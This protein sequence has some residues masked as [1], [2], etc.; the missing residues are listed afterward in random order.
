MKNA[1]KGWSPRSSREVAINAQPREK[2]KKKERMSIK[3]EERSDFRFGGW[4]FKLL[5]LTCPEFP[6]IWADERMFKAFRL[7][8]PIG[9]TPVVNSKPASVSEMLRAPVACRCDSLF[10]TP[11]APVRQASRQC[12]DER[13]LEGP[14][15]F[16]T[17]KIPARLIYLQSFF[18]SGCQ[19]PSTMCFW[20]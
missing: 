5:G 6:P 4:S 8:E 3:I 7:H 2:G 9:R 12:L 19:A 15:S 18:H 17:V 1:N 11:A 20:R 14:G 16:R 10:T 13:A